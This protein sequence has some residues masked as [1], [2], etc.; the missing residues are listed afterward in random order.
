LIFGKDKNHLYIN[1]IKVNHVNPKEFEAIEGCFFRDNQNAYYLGSFDEV[2]GGKDYRILGVNPHRVKV[3]NNDWAKADELLIYE[4]DTLLINEMEEFIPIDNNWGKTKNH[5]I[6]R[7]KII[8]GADLQSFEIIDEFD[9][10]DKYHIYEFGFIYGNEFIKSSVTNFNFNQNELLNGK[11]YEFTDIYTSL[12]PINEATTSEVYMAE[13]LKPLGFELLEYRKKDWSEGPLIITVTLSNKDCECF[14]EK[15]FF[16]NLDN[17]D[18]KVY[19]V[20]ERLH[21]HPRK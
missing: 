2:N 17:T 1:G 18:S 9:G 6:Y 12:L 21:C 11:A 3:L 10:K 16:T 8:N 15:A 14:V 20:T 4:K 19:R 13:W 7:D 5:I